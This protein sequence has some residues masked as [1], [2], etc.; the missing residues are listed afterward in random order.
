MH[1]LMFFFIYFI[2]FLSIIYKIKYIVDN[3]YHL[4]VKVYYSFILNFN[5]KA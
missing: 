1:L 5:N 2:I 3:V 4:L